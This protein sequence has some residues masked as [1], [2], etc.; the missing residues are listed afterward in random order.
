MRRP[1]LDLNMN[2]VAKSY[3]WLKQANIPQRHQDDLRLQIHGDL[4]LVS[5]T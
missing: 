2:D 1:R 5:M 3:M 4:S